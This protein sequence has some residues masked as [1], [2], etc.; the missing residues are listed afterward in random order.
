MFNLI[1]K[2]GFIID[3]TGNPRYKADM[4]IKNGKIVKIGC[5]KGN[6]N[7]VIN[8]KDLVV[9]P[10]FI[11]PHTHN[12]YILL[13]NP[14]AENYSRQGVTT[15]G[16]GNCGLSAAP[17]SEKYKEEL[18][19]YMAPFCMGAG[20]S[21]DWKS[22]DEFLHK[23]E[24]KG[25][26]INV[27]PFVGHNTI[28]I[29]VM[30]F[31]RRKANEKELKEMIKLLDESFKEGAVAFSTGLSYIPS[32]YSDTEEVIE[33]CKVVKKYNAYYVTHIRNNEGIEEALRI[34]KEVG[35]PI[36]ILHIAGPIYKYEIMHGRDILKEI[37]KMLKEGLEITFDQYPY[38][39]FC[40]FLH[41]LLP[42]WIFEGS[43]NKFIKR[44]ENRAIREKL[45]KELENLNFNQYVISFCYK[46]EN[47][48]YEGKTL[49][50]I[51]KNENKHPIDVLCDLLIKDDLNPHV[52]T[53]VGENYINY[54]IKSIKYPLTMIG[55]DSWAFPNVGKPHP[56]AYGTFPRILGRYVREMSILTLEE[57]VRK[58]TSFPARRMGLK[59]RGLIM[60]GMWADITI[61]DPNTIIDKATYED[62][63]QYP[64][65]IEYVLVNGEIVIEKGEYTGAMP[66]KVL[67]KF[68][69]KK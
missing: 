6:G 58:M 66:G 36:H 27:V 56:R 13:N 59:D 65:G 2:N 47:K 33:L 49:A 26:G 53:F 46:E 11:D 21:W 51:A 67:R 60:E 18:S 32:A 52:I 31:S 55:S 10:G 64:E 37:E 15:I 12:E 39:A 38:D 22:F 28:R 62:P 68:S 50:E 35:I 34:G 45:K 5:I 63:H 19:K 1:I 17:I 20:I 44:L 29:A 3:G 69:N 4:A 43:I 24:E 57:A 8:A 54:V 48:K 25:L 9:S 42:E 41:S 7:K 61:F 30:G 16:I 14:H 40:G 23:L